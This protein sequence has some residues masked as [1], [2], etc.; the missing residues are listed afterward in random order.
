MCNPPNVTRWICSAAI[1]VD[2]GFS[3]ASIGV[4]M[5]NY[6]FTAAAYCSLLKHMPNAEFVDCNLL[7]H[8]QRAVKS[9]RLSWI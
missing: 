7:V 1:L 9:E 5:D 8:W 6:Y 2:K 4:E 3:S